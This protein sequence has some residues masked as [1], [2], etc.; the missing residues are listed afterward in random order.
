MSLPF[1][2]VQFL[3]NFA[4]FNTTL[5]PV[6]VA[7]WIATLVLGVQLVLG[8]PRSAALGLLLAGQWMWAGAAYHA[9]FFT[10]INP[11]AW[12]FAAGFVAQALALLWYSVAARRLTFTGRPSIRHAGAAIFI[13][14]AL[15]YPAV[16][17]L[18]GHQAPRAPMFGVPCPTVLLTAGLLLAAEPPVSRWLL[19]IPVGWSVIGGSAA[20]LLRMPADW[21]LF[22]AGAALVADGL[23][24]PGRTARSRASLAERARPRVVDRFVDDPDYRQ[25]LAIDVH[26]RPGDIWPWLMQLG[27]QRGG[28]Y[29]Y[30]WLDRLFGFLDRPSAS[31][32]LP[33]LPDLR[34]GDVIPI[35]RGQGFPVAAVEPARSL[36]LAGEQEGVAWGWELALEPRGDRR[37]R[38]ISR[39]LGH[40]TRTWSSRLFL[41]ALRPAAFVMTHRMLTGIRRRAEAMAPPQP[42]PRRQAA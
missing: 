1:T 2:E 36:V 15:V 9:M 27:Y 7:L 6:L 17:Q 19:V 12:L 42:A 8:R 18:T 3:D 11:A 28:L 24:A 22:A 20:L 37:T 13:T 4:A 16:V 23:F 35:G 14:Y 41:L 33:G 25:V 26:A 21:M 31:Q 29:S 5:W 38:L 10:R 40:T 39:T 34:P 30:D 32:I